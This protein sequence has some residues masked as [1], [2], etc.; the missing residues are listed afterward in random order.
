VVADADVVERDGTALADL[1]E[2][3][4]GRPLELPFARDESGAR[5]ATSLELPLRLAPA[6]TAP[7]LERCPSA[8]SSRLCLRGSSSAG[9]STTSGVDCECECEWEWACEMGWE[10]AVFVA[11]A[12]IS[13]SEENGAGAGAGASSPGGAASA[14]RNGSFADDCCGW[15]RACRSMAKASVMVGLQ[16]S[17]LLAVSP[18]PPF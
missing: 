12:V 17:S 9:G 6:A 18:P 5:L 14:L 7:P 4:W 2:W 3:R 8:A 16:P 1:V 11:E 13:V 15:P 10:G